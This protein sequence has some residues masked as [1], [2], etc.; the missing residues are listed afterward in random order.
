MQLPNSAAFI[1]N[2]GRLFPTEK[3]LLP[4]LF[5]PRK[6]HYSLATDE[7]GACRFL[8]AR[9]CAIPAEARP[10]YCRLFPFWVLEGRITAF[11]HPE[12]L[13][14]REGRTVNLMMRIFNATPATIRDLQGRL[15][16]A[17]G[18]PPR[19]GMEFVNKGL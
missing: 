7:A 1:D 6:H 2:M 9:G 19:E 18:F 13:A 8:T 16:I 14:L 3:E 15:R 10:Y 11:E 4:R 5:H 12:C 17:W